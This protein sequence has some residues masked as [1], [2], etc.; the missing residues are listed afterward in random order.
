MKSKAFYTENKNGTYTVY[1]D[2]RVMTELINGEWVYF[3]E[4]TKEEAERL[5]ND[6]NETILNTL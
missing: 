2:N 1:V 5:V 4:V 3:N 6:Y